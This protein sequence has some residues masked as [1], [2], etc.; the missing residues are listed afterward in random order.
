MESHPQ[1]QDP[2]GAGGE[3]RGRQRVQPALRHAHQVLQTGTR[4]TSSG[5]VFILS[6]LL[7]K[8]LVKME[9]VK[10][11][12]GL[13]KAVLLY[14]HLV[15]VSSGFIILIQT[16]NTRTVYP[17]TVTAVHTCPSN[18]VFANW[19]NVD[20]PSHVDASDL[21]GAFSILTEQMCS[22]SCLFALWS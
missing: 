17:Q 11:L 1:N 10:L 20:E 6:G 14:F 13:F 9:T 16:L 19:R 5:S 21:H 12:F 4:L 18:G 7:S 22:S 15:N 8:H 3:A 2:A